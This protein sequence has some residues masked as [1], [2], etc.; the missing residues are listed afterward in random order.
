MQ[1]ELGDTH[2]YEFDGTADVTHVTASGD[3]GALSTSVTAHFLCEIVFLLF[4]FCVIGGEKNKKRIA[5]EKEKKNQ[6]E[7]FFF[8]V[9]VCCLLATPQVLPI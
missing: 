6:A 9:V 5:L 8:K 7:F 3:D 2:V 1:Y 4:L